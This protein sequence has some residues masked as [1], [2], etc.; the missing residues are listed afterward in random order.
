MATSSA[1]L[2]RN[3]CFLFVHTCDAEA[4]GTDKRQE[5]VL[6]GVNQGGEHQPVSEPIVSSGHT[7]PL[8]IFGKG[9]V[10]LSH[11][12][13]SDFGVIE[14]NNHMGEAQTSSTSSGPLACRSVSLGFGIS[15]VEQGSKEDPNNDTRH[16]R[17]RNPRCQNQK[18]PSK[19]TI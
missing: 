1:R 16:S 12:T 14:L 19:R 6:E 10:C 11:I 5:E 9:L 2:S 4:A 3:H 17:G 13:I 18:Q 8:A 7:T 15:H